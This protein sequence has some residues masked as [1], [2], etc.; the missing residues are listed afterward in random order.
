MSARKFTPV[1]PAIWRPGRFMSL[2]SSDAKLLH[3]YLM[4]NEHQNSAGAYR[5]PD[6][7]ACA[8]LGWT[9]EKYRQYRAEL[10]EACL[11]DFDDAT[12]TVYIE[13]WFKHSPPQNDKHALGTRRMIE[14]I[15][16]DAIRE[17]VEAEFEEAESRRQAERNPI[18][19]PSP[20]SNLTSTGYMARNNGRS[21]F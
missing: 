19:G 21:P 7:Y 13:Q 14:A 4:T 10:V 16:S 8:D 11:I 2:A 12:S 20:R 6:G 1:S 17:K 5:L 18:D 15:D 3:F 9:P